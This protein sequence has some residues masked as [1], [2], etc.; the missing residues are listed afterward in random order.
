M[1]D[2]RGTENMGRNES[3]T[4]LLMKKWVGITENHNLP[5][6]KPDFFLQAAE[7]NI[8]IS[9]SYLGA[10]VFGADRSGNLL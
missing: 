3:M 1:G 5:D 9:Y 6:K 7:S 2:K 8:I 4:E 10:N